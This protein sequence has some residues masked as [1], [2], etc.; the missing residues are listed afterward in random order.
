MAAVAQ[1]HAAKAPQMG[2]QQRRR[3]QRRNRESRLVRLVLPALVVLVIFAIWEL[4]PRLGLVN[5][6]ILP[7]ASE[8]LKALV[9]V[10]QEDF[11][12]EALRTTAMETFLGFLLGATFGWILGTLIGTFR[13][14]QIA[15]YPPAVALQVMPSV[16]LVPVL[17]TWFGFGMTSKVVM[18]AIICFFP[19]LL[20]AVVGLQTVDQDSRTLMRSLGAGPFEEYRKLLLPASLPVLFAGLKYGLTLALVGAIVAE[21]VGGSEGLGVLIK[22]FN[23]QLEVRLGFAVV[24]VLLAFGLAL[25]G[26]M[27]LIERKVVFWKGRR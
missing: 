18:A 2:P 9:E 7:P 1:D 22:T 10:V 5:E 21:F 14:A 11:F 23:F 12:W 19:V 17:L 4:L 27:S 13:L 26:L 16:A 25:W 6:I 3:G 8:V 24:L 15:F 20:N